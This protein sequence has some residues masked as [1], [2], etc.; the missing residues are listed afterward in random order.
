MEMVPSMWKSL[1]QNFI[2]A[3][4]TCSLQPQIWLVPQVPGLDSKPTLFALSHNLSSFNSFS[5]VSSH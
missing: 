1:F 5:T 2:Q 4:P 3:T